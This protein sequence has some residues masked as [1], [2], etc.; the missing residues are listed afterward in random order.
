M[1]APG[2]FL[3]LDLGTKRVGVAVCDELHLTTRPLAQ[4]ARGSWKNLLLSVKGL[5]EEFA[6]LGL[7]IGLPLNL[8]G[9]EGT[10]AW[11][12]RRVAR[13]FALSL[14]IPVYLQDERLTSRAA[15]EFLGIHARPNAAQRAQIDSQA[16]AI[17]LSDFLAQPHPE[18]RRITNQ[19]AP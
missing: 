5:V 6:P 10:A 17:I 19:D 14:K 2:R 4:L 3:V 11:D 1:N 9:T 15:E 16:A 18:Q 13:N 7:V 12:A 8:D